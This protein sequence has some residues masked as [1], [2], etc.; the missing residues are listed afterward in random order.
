[1]RVLYAEDERALSDAIV[2]ILKMEG[3]EVDAVYD[4]AEALEHIS[5]GAYD[6]AVLDIMMP[7]LDGVAVLQKMRERGDYTPVLLLTAK[8]QVEDRILGLSA[9]ADDY[10]GKPFATGELIARLRAMGRRMTQYQVKT[11]SLGNIT[12]DC[13]SLELK[14]DIGSLRLSSKE[15]QLLTYFLENRDAVLSTKQIF[16]R[17][18]T[19]EDTQGVVELYI[20]YLRNKLRQIGS[21][22]NIVRTK[23]GFRLAENR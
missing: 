6:A 17:L 3:F 20:S 10:L 5:G 23:G 14:S 7:R 18:W 4:G 16:D 12:L 15:S 11:L 8:T 21:H 19:Q 1:M 13:E 9:G 2:E 22:V